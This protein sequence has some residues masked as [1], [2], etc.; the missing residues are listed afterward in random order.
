MEKIKTKDKILL[1]ALDLFSERGYD[2]ASIDLI[3]EAVG[4]KGPSIYAHYKGKEDILNSLIVRMEQ[5]Y[6]E[7]F[8]NIFNLDK[9]PETL[10]EFKEDC[11]R[12]IE[13]VMRD[14]QI[15]KVRRF[16]MKEQFRDEKIAALTSKHQLTGN[17]EM[18]AWM[19][20]KMMEKKLIQRF[21]PRLLALELISPITLMLGITDREPHRTNEMLTLMDAHL[22]HFIKIY[23][24]EKEL[25]HEGGSFDMQRAA[26]I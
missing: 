20:E 16:C 15:K 22:T 26:M 8:G 14:T 9:I 11:F 3:A 2:E 17:Q 25:I 21:D 13:F 12:R 6:D 24:I 5:R 10:H 23:G 7:N 1:A 4:I 18:Y 19:L